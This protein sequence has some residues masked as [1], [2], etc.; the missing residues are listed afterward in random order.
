MFKKRSVHTELTN[1]NWIKNLQDIQTTTQLEEFTMLFMA[2]STVTLND[3]DDTI[4]W[5]W[6][7]NGC[8][9]VAFAYECQFLG[10]MIRFPTADIWRAKAEQKCKF[11]SWLVM[12]NRVLIADNLIKRS[13]PYD[14]ICSLCNC[15][16]ETTP[17]MLTQ[18]N[19]TVVVW[20]RTAQKYNL[21]NYEIMAA[22]GGPVEWVQYLFSYGTKQTKR[23]NAGILF[24][25]WW[26]I[27]KECNKRIFEHIEVSGVQLAALIQ[28]AIHLQKLASSSTA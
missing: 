11:Y 27:W 12:H 20:D 5:R 3:Q 2:L 25:F 7:S 4:S 24:T 23:K 26:L 1:C 9:S 19:Y 6:T 17:H 16:E 14:P 8:Y 10:A 18:C 22:K 21:P 13:C 28:E 15:L